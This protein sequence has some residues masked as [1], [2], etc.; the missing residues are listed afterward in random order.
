MQLIRT[1]DGLVGV[2][3]RNAK[4][5][6]WVDDYDHLVRITQAHFQKMDMNTALMHK[7]LSVALDTMAQTGHQVAHFGI[8]GSFM[9]TEAEV[10]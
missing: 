3:F 10:A 2:K 4:K 1:D 9:Y 7:E 5:I 6:V 8:L